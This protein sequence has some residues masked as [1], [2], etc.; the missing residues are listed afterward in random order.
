MFGSPFECLSTFSFKIDT[1][2]EHLDI[3]ERCLSEIVRFSPNIKHLH[4]LPPMNLAADLDLA[5]E[6]DDHLPRP[7][8]LSYLPVVQENLLLWRTQGGWDKLKK[9]KIYRIGHLSAFAGQTPLL[10]SLTVR[11]MSD[12]ILRSSS[13]L[14]FDNMGPLRQ[15]IL[16]GHIGDRIPLGSLQRY[17]STLT[18]LRIHKDFSTLASS[19]KVY[20]K[21][22]YQLNLICPNI[23]YL[24]LDLHPSTQWMYSEK[25]YKWHIP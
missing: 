14:V 2:V 22:I 16:I 8:E 6:P 23:Q 12:D 9:L 10:E 20:Q 18:D 21:D 19:L 25:V 1:N 17:G 3:Q 5:F 13:N 24:E 4:A 7:E 15:I 11:V